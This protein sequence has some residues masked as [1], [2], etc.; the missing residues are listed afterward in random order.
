MLGALDIFSQ[1]L[2]NEGCRANVLNFVKND[3]VHKTIIDY[4]F[5]F[6]VSNKNWL[7]IF[8]LHPTKRNE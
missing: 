2:H 6:T 8:G 1:F 3:D 4:F 5:K 7:K